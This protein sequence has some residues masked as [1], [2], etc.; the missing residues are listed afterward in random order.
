MAPVVAFSGAEIDVEVHASLA[1]A[2]LLKITVALLPMFRLVDVRVAEEP[3]KSK[4]EYESAAKLMVL[5]V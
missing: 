4:T 5:K 1:A 3:P 2:K